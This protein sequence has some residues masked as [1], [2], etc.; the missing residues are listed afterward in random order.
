MGKRSFSS[1]PSHVT[2]QINHLIKT[3][4]VLRISTHIY[5]VS[6]EIDGNIFI[7]QV[8]I[9]CDPS[10]RLSQKHEPCSEVF[11]TYLWGF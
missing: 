11:N 4:P 10:N 6:K 9:A 3:S 5:D 7:F 2:P 8:N 1:K